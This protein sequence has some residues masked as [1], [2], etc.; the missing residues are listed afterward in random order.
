MNGERECTEDNEGVTCRFTCNEGFHFAIP[1]AQEYFC[2]FDNVWKPS[3]QMPISDCSGGMYT[4]C[5]ILS[6]LPSV[7]LVTY[8]MM[9][10][11]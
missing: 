1:P 3:D 10:K 4:F 7:E 9:I 5:F 11:L 8:K 6:T 2:A